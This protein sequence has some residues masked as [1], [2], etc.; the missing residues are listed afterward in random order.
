VWPQNSIKNQALE[1]YV[2]RLVSCKACVTF[3]E[4]EKL[5]V[6]GEV[7]HRQIEVQ[8]RKHR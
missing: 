5:N 3:L 8:H 7:E 4:S 6:K 1:N 2:V